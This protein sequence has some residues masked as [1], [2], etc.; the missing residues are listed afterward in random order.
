LAANVVDGPPAAVE[1]EPV[2][3]TA[4]LA[5]AMTRAAKSADLVVMAAAPADFTPATTSDTK[6]KKSGGAGVELSLVQTP[7]VLAGL[8]KSREDPRQVL[9]GFAAET[10]RDGAD[11]VALGR[12]KLARK[13]CDLLVLNAVGRDLVFG[14]EDNEITL[15]TAR[16]DQEAVADGPYAGPKDALAHRIWNAAL[17]VRAAR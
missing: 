10:P 17:A 15:L 6:I 7:D 14:S 8:A 11:L 12:A 16:G 2:T 9:I 5:A 3:S 4:D 1:V 13:K